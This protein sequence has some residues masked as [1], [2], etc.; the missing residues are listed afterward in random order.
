[1]FAMIT[2]NIC[3]IGASPEYPDYKKWNLKKKL[4]YIIKFRIKTV[5]THPRDIIPAVI[6]S[7][8]LTLIF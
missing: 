3:W 4:G 8:I 5:L 7:F 2:D 6:T 1:M